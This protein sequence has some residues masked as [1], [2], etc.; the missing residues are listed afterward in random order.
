MW[1][2]IWG[3]DYWSV[4]LWRRRNKGRE[5]LLEWGKPELWE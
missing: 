4:D 1:G 5:N 2:F 3:W